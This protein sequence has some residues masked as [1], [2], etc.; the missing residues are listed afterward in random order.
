MAQIDLIWDF[1]VSS[2]NRHWAIPTIVSVVLACVAGLWKITRPSTVHV[3]IAEK[4]EQPSSSILR[5][6]VVFLQHL[7]TSLAQMGARAARILRK[8]LIQVWGVV[9]VSCKRAHDYVCY[10]IPGLP[11]VVRD[12]PVPTS[13]SLF[14]RMQESTTFYSERFAEAFPALREPRAYTNPKDIRRRLD[15]LLRTPLSAQNENGTGERIPIWWTRGM[16]DMHLSQCNWVKPGIL[17]MDHA[18]I[19]ITKV[20]AIPGVVYWQNFVYVECEPLPPT[21]LYAS[22]DGEYGRLRRHPVSEEYAIY[23]YRRFTRAE[24][25]DGAYERRGRMY[26]F[27]SPPQLRVRYLTPYNFLLVPIGSPVRSPGLERDLEN[28]LNELLEGTASESQFVDW[29]LSLP[30]RH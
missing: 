30:R 19:K 16:T 7:V 9:S 20:L 2:E 17:L 28:H 29:L 8:N 10:L 12:A 22:L 14:F 11:Y 5:V 15:R 3:P 21:G 23:R 6:F 1:I 4:A 13:D 24:Y 18:E 27:Q 26:S 25:D